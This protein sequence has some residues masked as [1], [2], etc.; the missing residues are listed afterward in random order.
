MIPIGAEE[1][2]LGIALGQNK[3][4]HIA[5]KFFGSRSIADLKMDMADQ[6][7]IRNALPGPALPCA[8]DT[9]RIQ[10]LGCHQ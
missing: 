2:R 6:P 8:K 10:S 3:A 1:T 5:V 7:M 9:I 4:E